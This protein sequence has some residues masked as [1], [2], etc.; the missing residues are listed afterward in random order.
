MIAGKRWNRWFQGRTLFGGGLGL[1]IGTLTLVVHWGCQGKMSPTAPLVPVRGLSLSFSIPIS[2]D[3][4]DSLLGVASNEVLYQVTGPDMA[5]VTGVAGPFTTSS[6]SGEVDFSLSIPQ[7]AARL[8][9]F[10]LSNASN[11]QPL[12]LG[13]VQSDINAG[14]VSDIWVTMGSVIRNCYS[15]DTSSYGV[16]TAGVTATTTYFSFWSDALSTSLTSSSDISVTFSGGFSFTAQNGDGIAYLGNGPMVNFDTVPA[17][18]AFVSSSIAAKQAAGVSPTYLQAGDVYCVSLVAGGVGGHAW[19][20]VVNPNQPFGLFPP[21]PTGP[22]FLFRVNTTLPYYAYDPTQA[23]VNTNCPA[24]PPTPTNVPTNTFTPTNSPTFTNSPTITDTP[25]ITPTP[26]NTSTANT[27]FTITPTP[28]PTATFIPGYTVSAAVSCLL[29]DGSGNCQTFVLTIDANSN[30][31]PAVS[32]A[33]VADLTNSE[34]VWVGPWNYTGSGTSYSVTLTGGDFYLSSPVSTSLAVTLYNGSQNQILGYAIPADSPLTLEAPEEYFYNYADEYNYLS[35]ATSAEDGNC[36]NF[37]FYS[38]LESPNSNPVT[39][40]IQF[41][42]QTNGVTVFLGPVTTDGYLANTWNLSPEQ[43]GVTAVGQQA[44]SQVFEAQLIDA[45]TDKV[46]DSKSL[47]SL[48]LEYPSDYIE[49]CSVTCLASDSNNGACQSFLLTIDADAPASVMETSYAAVT[50]TTSGEYVW[51]GPW[52]YTGSGTSYAVTLTGGDIGVTTAT[53]TSLKVILYESDQAT[54]LDSKIPSGSPLT[55]EAPEEYF[56]YYYGD[57]YNYLSCDTTAEDGNCVNFNFYTE[58]EAAS[59]SAPVTSEIELIDLSNSV[60]A[61]LGPVT[62]AE[63]GYLDSSWNLSPEQFGVTLGQQAVSQVFEARLID[64]NTDAILDT[65]SLGSLNLE[66]P[67][68]YIASS[69]ITCLTSDSNNGACQSFLLTIDADAPAS[70]METSYASVTNTTNGQYVWV[71]PWTYTGSGTSYAVTLTGGDL[72]VNTATDTSL[73]VIL[74]SSDQETILDSNTPL[75][76]PLTLEAPEEYFYYYD[77]YTYNYLSC[78]TTAEDGNCLNFNFDSELYAP[79][80]TPVTS[81][82]ELINLS[83]SVTVVLGPVTVTDYYAENTWSLSPDQFGVTAVGQQALSQVFEAQLIDAN[84]DAILDTKALGS[85]NLE[86]PSAFIASSLVTCLQSNGSGCQSFLLNIDAEG[87]SGIPETSYATITNMANNQSVSVGPWSY[88]GTDSNSYGVTLS[89]GDFGITAAAAT[90]LKVTLFSPNGAVQDTAIPNGSPL[91]LVTAQ[92]YLAESYLTCQTASEDGNCVTFTYNAYL[93]VP[94]ASPVVSFVNLLDLTNGS[95]TMLGPVT[96]TGDENLSYSVTLTGASFGMTV[97]QAGISQV[98]QAQLFDST[99]T[100]ILATKS[101]GVLSIE[102]SGG[103]AVS[104]SGA[105][106]SAGV[107]DGSGNWQSFVLNINANSS[108]GPAVSYA[109]VWDTSF[110][111]TGLFLGRQF[112][113]DVAFVVQ[114]LREVAIHER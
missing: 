81:L 63:G 76:S 109:Q 82:I 51:V 73:K 67:A 42:D 86:H 10:Q 34:G 84:T 108:G 13:A 107:T 96:N 79:G 23:D 95:S 62:V 40:L 90:T 111:L 75:G 17:T 56:Y 102:N 19:V 31:N 57:N 68:N 113:L 105:S 106:L 58:L 69:S 43:F 28:I 32:Y 94:G 52:S 80:S 100:E 99:L 70:V 21:G 64:A 38:E 27:T 91:T 45:N 4:K 7:G 98:F 71:G 77:D 103:A 12:A 44:L 24:P 85:L 48:N 15:V 59:V 20:Q 83:N 65:K 114:L 110:R 92:E 35:C 2:N 50:N 29:A 22:K 78:A 41:T 6:Q 46:L 97:G 18:V 49:S 14:G 37:N 104:L 74:Y 53:N 3:V 11:N 16:S 9:T 33:Y 26:L 5:A 60:T 8:M 55:L 93:D 112:E 88:T 54:T 61:I 47:E 36:V 25:T 66:N 101:T 30:G 87:P 89:A 72:G 1:V 39:S